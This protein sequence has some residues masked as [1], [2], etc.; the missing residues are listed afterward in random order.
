MS[1]VC[2]PRAGVWLPVTPSHPFRVLSAYFLLALGASWEGQ[3][4]APRPGT[5]A[6]WAPPHGA[7]MA[8]Q[9]SRPGSA[10]EVMSEEWA[11]HPT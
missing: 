6:A 2:V 5:P 1:G 10:G 4:K 3:V 7:P 9:R 11:F 8:T